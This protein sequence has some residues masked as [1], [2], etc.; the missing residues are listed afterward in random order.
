M[1]EEDRLGP[2]EQ[3]KNLEIRG[4]TE[5]I[6][7]VDDD[8]FI[9]ELGEEMLCRFGYRVV[10]A[11]DGESALEIFREQKESISLV[12]LDLIMPGMGGSKCLKEL[13]KISPRARILVASGYSPDA[14]TKGA[15]EVGAAAFINKP[16]DNKQ[17]LE[18]VRK[19][20]DKK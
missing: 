5:T 1:L 12:I 18:L 13:L 16:Y 8:H 2:L 19:I 9:R 15:L 10:A 6:L 4:G 14:S 17:L 11:S 7:L 3:Q 20:L